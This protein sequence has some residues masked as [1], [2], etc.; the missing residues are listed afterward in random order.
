M[1]VVHVLCGEMR[2]GAC[3]MLGPSGST[4]QLLELW[5]Q[6]LSWCF[7]GAPH[8]LKITADPQT[9]VIWTWG[10]GRQSESSRKITDLLFLYLL[11][12]IKFELSSENVKILENLFLLLWAWQLPSS[13]DFSDGIGGDTNNVIFFF[14]ERG[15]SYNEMPWHCQIYIIKLI[16]VGQ[17][18]PNDPGMLL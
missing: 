7:H 12:V 5:A 4:V 13:K 15:I 1:R 6:L 17:N 11:P 2:G 3:S 18:F 8:L 9:I 16:N 10:F 14:F